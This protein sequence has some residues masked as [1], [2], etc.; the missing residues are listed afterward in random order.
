MRC[1]ID[2]DAL[3]HGDEMDINNNNKQTHES[4]ERERERERDTA[5]Q[6]L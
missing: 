6:L 2:N 3:Y 1:I 5:S 4:R